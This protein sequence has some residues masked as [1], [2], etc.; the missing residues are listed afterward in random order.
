M[1]NGTLQGKTAIVTGAGTGLGRAAALA[2]AVEGANVVLAGRRKGK[3]DAVAAEITAAGGR[4]LAIQ[5][6]I[7]S[8]ADVRR[9][10]TSAVEAFGQI[11]I[12][13]NNAAVFEP[14]V[15]AETG[16]AEWN[17]QIGI[18]LTGAFLTTR[19]VLPHMRARKYGRIINITS[20]L[21]SNGAGGYAAY[22]ASK[23]G[24]ESLT[25]TTAEEESEHGVLANLFNPGTVKS[26]MHATG[27]DPAEVVP[28]LVRLAALPG[29]GMSGQ[30]ITATGI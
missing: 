25:R 14:G 27:Q 1:G 7:S 17:L 4:A 24:L 11:D 5:A 15:V 13:V 19:E 20:G 22:S 16:L 2:F 30:L 23:A 12:L 21:A 8:E 10:V 26:E 18:N 29:H 6:D 9:L 28:A 3:V